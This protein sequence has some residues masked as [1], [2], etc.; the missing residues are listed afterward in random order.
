M[1]EADSKGQDACYF[2]L[3]AQAAENNDL[4]TC[5]REMVMIKDPLLRA[6]ATRL[7]ISEKPQG[8]EIITATNL[9]QQLTEAEAAD[10]DRSWNR[11]HLW[12][13]R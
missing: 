9:C 11:P 1:K 5:L 3:V 6:S 13:S 12:K 10:C 4:E 8:M 2:D 7:V